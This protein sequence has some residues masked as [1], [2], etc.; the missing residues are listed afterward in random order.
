MSRWS[1]SAFLPS[2]ARKLPLTIPDASRAL[3]QGASF[4]R[5]RWRLR[6]VRR[7]RMGGILQTKTMGR[8]NEAL[9]VPSCTNH[10][11]VGATRRRGPA[12]V[13]CRRRVRC[14]TTA[15]GKRPASSLSCLGSSQHPRGGTLGQEYEKLSLRGALLATPRRCLRPGQVRR[16][17]GLRRSPRWRKRSAGWLGLPM[18]AGASAPGGE[19]GRAMIALSWLGMAFH[20]RGPRR[21]AVSHPQG[22]SHSQF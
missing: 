12:L 13:A 6:A 21:V 16:F 15:S 2:V 9:C 1:G 5:P 4:M 19:Q 22:G 8:A 3:S 20:G 18:S 7:R 17:D 14:L 11:I 10:N